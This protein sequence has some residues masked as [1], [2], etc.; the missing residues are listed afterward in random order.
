MS[1]EY[2][3]ER[4]ADREDVATLLRGIADG[5]AAGSIRLGD[6]EA[7]AIAVPD[8][9]ELEIEFE[10]DDGRSLEVELEWDEETAV[11]P[12]ADD[13]P[14]GAHGEGDDSLAESDA[15]D[16]DTGDGDDSSPAADTVDADIADVDTAID[17]GDETVELPVGSA[18]PRES[19]ARFEVFADRAEEWRWRLVHRNGNVIATSGEG[20]T[21]KHNALKGLRSVMTNA[22]DAETVEED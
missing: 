2:A 16:A 3:L 10:T 18:E 11:E 1:E 13:T 19:L 20:Y 17:D 14:A 12:F 9:V 5:V 4:T 21:R 15:G 6:E 22:A 8:A 7:I